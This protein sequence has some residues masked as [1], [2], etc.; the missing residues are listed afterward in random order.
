[1]LDEIEKGEVQGGG[2]ARLGASRGW[3]MTGSAVKRWTLCLS[4]DSFVEKGEVQEGEGSRFSFPG[5]W[6]MTGSASPRWTL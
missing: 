4:C 6:R 2:G 1:M 5:G 3:R